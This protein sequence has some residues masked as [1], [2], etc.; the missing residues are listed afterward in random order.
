MENEVRSAYSSQEHRLIFEAIAAHDPELAEQRMMG[1]IAN[2]R[3]FI[4]ARE[5]E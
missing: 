1:H 3:E 2:A 5:A 4:Q